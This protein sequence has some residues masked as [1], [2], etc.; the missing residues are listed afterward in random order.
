MAKRSLPLGSLYADTQVLVF[1][2]CLG[3]R[4]LCAAGAWAGTAAGSA[5][6]EAFLLVQ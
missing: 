6:R 5:F 2:Q 1:Q 4:K 3:S